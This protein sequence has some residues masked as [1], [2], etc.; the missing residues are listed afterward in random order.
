VADVSQPRER[1]VFPAGFREIPFAGFF[2]KG[3][4]SF[5]QK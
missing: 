5:G 1:Y 2:P 3:R 4:L